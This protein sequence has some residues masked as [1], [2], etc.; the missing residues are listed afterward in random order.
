[1]NVL[2]DQSQSTMLVIFKLCAKK[3]GTLPIP[4]KHTPPFYLRPSSSFNKDLVAFD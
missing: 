1:M 4:C 3:G 2:T